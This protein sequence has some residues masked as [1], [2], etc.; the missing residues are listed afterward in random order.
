MKKSIRR[1][2]IQML[3]AIV[4]YH[5]LLHA[6]SGTNIIAGVFCPGPHLP[7]W[8][9][10]LIILFILLRCY[11]LFLPGLLLSRLALIWMRRRGKQ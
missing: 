10:P 6:L 1:L 9:R 3:V 5:F 8:Y 7:G 2:L 4:A 11:L